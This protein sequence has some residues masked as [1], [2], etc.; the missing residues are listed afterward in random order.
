[1]EQFPRSDLTVTMDY[2]LRAPTG[3]LPSARACYWT[4]QRAVGA[5]GKD[6]R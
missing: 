6:L 1:M 5:A 4:G 3:R 2:D